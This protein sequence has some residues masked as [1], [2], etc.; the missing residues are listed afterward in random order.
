MQERQV[1]IKAEKEALNI[2]KRVEAVELSELRMA[3]SERKNRIQ[4]LQ[5]KY[6]NL[7]SCLGTAADGTPLTT[8]YIKIQSAQEKYA[9][10]EQGDKLDETIRKTE[11]EIQSMENTLRIVNASND[12]YKKSLGLVEENG[13][14]QMEQKK[15][16][17]EMYNEME[18]IRHRRA[19]LELARAD[20][21]VK[22]M[23]TVLVSYI[24][25]KSFKN[26]LIL[27]LNR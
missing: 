18:R 21:K 9:L 20:L 12:K 10:Q 22:E 7:M 3:I 17:E 16:N 8:T 24:K 14:E 27:H 15:L 4:Q 23:G 25:M 6:D 1:E 13:P 11:C 2:R 26:G 19:Q 5:T